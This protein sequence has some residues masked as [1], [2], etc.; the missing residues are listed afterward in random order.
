MPVTDD[1]IERKLAKITDYETLLPH[2]QQFTDPYTLFKG[3]Y[4][5][6]ICGI[7]GAG[8][9]TLLLTLLKKMCDLGYTVLARDDGGLES[10]YL[11]PYVPI[12]FWVP[13]GCELK[14][15]TE[16][17]HD[18]AIYDPSKPMEIMERVFE[19]PF[20]LVI[21]DAYSIDPGLS[22]KF[23]ADMLKT[24]IFKCMQTSRKDKR[25]L[26]LSMD[27]LND[28]IQP[29]GFELTKRHASVRSLLEY[30]IRKLRK[31]EVTLIATTHRF[32]QLGISAR[33]QFSYIFLKRMYGWDAWDFLSK[34]LATSNNKTFWAILKDVT[35]MDRQYF[36]MFDPW[37]RFDRYEF[38]DINRP[39]VDYEL[40]GYLTEKHKTK[41]E[42]VWK[43][44]VVRLVEELNKLG[45]SYRKLGPLLDMSEANLRSIITEAEERETGDSEEPIQAVT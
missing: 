10:M 19:Y 40:I 5:A 21:F 6:L 17:K 14:L 4:H 38:A 25:K 26:I 13:K 34:S 33:S 7:T 39:E 22:A 1:Y 2:V 44:R 43:P 32:T 8:K 11:L 31:H 12:R 20:N 36:Y 23:W 41:D 35:S 9:S 16:Y 28:I 24:L 42:Q 3:G 29:K 27:E 18:I 15:K 37:N 45:Y 30:N